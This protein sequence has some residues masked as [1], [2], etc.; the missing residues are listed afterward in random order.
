M[1]LEGRADGWRCVVVMVVVVVMMVVLMVVVMVVMGLS[2]EY[3]ERRPHH[4]ATTLPGFLPASSA[5]RDII[6]VTAA[7][8]PDVSDLC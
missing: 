8:L 4:H 3:R 5:R 7:L 1:V 6:R 2:R